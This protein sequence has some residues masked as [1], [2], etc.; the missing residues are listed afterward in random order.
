[1]GGP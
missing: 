1:V